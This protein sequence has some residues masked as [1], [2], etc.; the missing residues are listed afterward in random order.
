ML[1]G[2]CHSRLSIFCYK[3]VPDHFLSP[4]GVGDNLRSGLLPLGVGARPDSDSLATS[5]CNGF[6]RQPRITVTTN[7]VFES[8]AA[9]NSGALVDGG[10]GG[11]NVIDETAPGGRGFFDPALCIAA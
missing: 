7:Y 8:G 2:L 1:A 10:A 3:T 6:F 9:E 11:E 5:R 4:W